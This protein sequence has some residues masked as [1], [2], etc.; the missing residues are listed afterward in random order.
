VASRRDIPLPRRALLSLGRDVLDGGGKELSRGE[1]LEVLFG[2]P[3][4]AGAVDDFS[5][6]FIPSD[7]F[8]G[9]GRSQ[10]VFG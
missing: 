2:V 7:L 10:E 5:G 3:A 9:E 8:E 4:A 6:G 1:D